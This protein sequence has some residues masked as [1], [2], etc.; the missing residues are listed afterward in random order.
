MFESRYY[1]TTLPA[2]RAVIAIMQ[3]DD[4]A[5]F[6]VRTGDAREPA[7]QLLWRLRLPIAANFRPHHYALHPRTLNLA[8]QQRIPITIRRA[9]PARRFRLRGCGNGILAS[10][11][12]VA[13]RGAR[14][15]KQ[16]GVRLRVISQ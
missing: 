12:L 8:V 10:G 4:V 2:E 13:N 3:Q 14:L 9:H 11:Q 1:V 15:E 6:A 7:N 16:I 5:V